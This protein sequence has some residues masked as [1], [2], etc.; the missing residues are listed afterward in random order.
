MGLRTLP[1]SSAP[2][3][4]LT[5]V[6]RR[7]TP[8]ADLGEDMLAALF[9]L[10][11]LATAE[12]QE[13]VRISRGFVNVFAIVGERTVLVDAHNPN[14]EEWIWRKL[15]KN[16]KHHTLFNFAAC[17]LKWKRNHLCSGSL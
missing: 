5:A 16:E 4:L 3:I 8:I 10:L 2:G 17:F 7:L 6:W 12:A 14:Q 13:V 1:P 11:T 9:V 15:K